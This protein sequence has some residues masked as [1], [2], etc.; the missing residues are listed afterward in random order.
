MA[1]YTF[2]ARDTKPAD[3]DLVERAKSRCE[4]QGMNFSALI[5]RLLREHEDDQRAREVSNSKSS[6]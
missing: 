4:Q 3:V 6:S 1:V 5:L 2:S